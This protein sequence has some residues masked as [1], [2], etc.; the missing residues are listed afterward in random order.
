MHGYAGVDD[1]LVW[2]AVECDLPGLREVLARLLGAPGRGHDAGP[3]DGPPG[4]AL[5]AEGVTEP[6]DAAAL[7]VVGTDCR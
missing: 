3:R 2:E 6:A 5:V 1:R 4:T 7:A